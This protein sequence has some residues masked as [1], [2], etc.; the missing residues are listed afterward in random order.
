MSATTDLSQKA[1]L[2]DYLAAERTFLAWVR[3]S[4]A[5]IAFGFVIERFG[6]LL[7]ELGLKVGLGSNSSLRA[8]PAGI[9]G[10]PT[11]TLSALLRGFAVVWHRAH[12]GW[13]PRQCVRR[14]AAQSVSQRTGWR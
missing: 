12:C 2:R 1:G 10:R 8:L 7:R 6:L 11:V 14:V 9:P 4:I 13:S 3:T 5:V